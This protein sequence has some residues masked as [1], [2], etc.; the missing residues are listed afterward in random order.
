MFID[1]QVEPSWSQCGVQ[2]IRYGQVGA[3][4]VK[5]QFKGVVVEEQ[6]YGICLGATVDFD[7]AYQ[8]DVYSYDD[9]RAVVGVLG[10]VIN[11]TGLK[12]YEMERA[13]SRQKQVLVLW[14]AR[15]R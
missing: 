5:E 4:Q 13:L 3:L 2:S 10:G 11:P 7:G 15:L 12:R 8:T 9:R 1:A 6:K 14:P